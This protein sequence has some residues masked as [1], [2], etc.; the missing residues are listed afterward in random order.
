LAEEF[1]PEFTK[2]PNTKTSDAFGVIVDQPEQY[3]HAANPTT[4]G[5][6]APV[7]IIM[8]IDFECPYCQRSYP[9]V[10]ELTQRYGDVIELIFKHFPLESIHPDA[11]PAAR[12]A[13]CADDQG[14]FWPYYDVLFT[15]RQLDEASLLSHADTLGLDIQTFSTCLNSQ[16]HEQEIEQDLLDGIDIGVRGTPTYVVNGIK[17]E[18]VLSKEIWDAVILEQLQK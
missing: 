13:S 7:Q 9:I 16:K 2:D 5:E 17:I 1:N 8:F 15:S 10:K 4:G 12:G 3:I 11:L 6:N 14:A 18:G